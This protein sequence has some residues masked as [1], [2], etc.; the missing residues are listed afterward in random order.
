MPDYQRI[1]F[2]LALLAAI[3]ITAV[4]LLMLAWQTERR[5]SQARIEG[6]LLDQQ[7]N[8]TD[9]RRE[10][11]ERSR[12]TLKGRM[13]EQMAPLLAGFAYLPADARFLG[14]PIDYI[15]FKGYTEVRD[16]RAEDG[17]LEIVLLEIKQGKSALSTSQRAIARAIERGRVRFEV[18]RISEEGEVSTET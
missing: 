5:R 7:K 2:I 15:V 14:D 16:N 13:A 4:I 6:L 11:V 18:C 17:E 3:A 12:S 9:A 1:V 10:S 8:L